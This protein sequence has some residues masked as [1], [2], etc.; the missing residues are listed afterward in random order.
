ML[1]ENENRTFTP[2]EILALKDQKSCINE[3]G[4]VKIIPAKISLKA[5]IQ[6]SIHAFAKAIEVDYEFNFGNEEGE[7]FLEA[8]RIRNRIAHPKSA[9]CWVISDTEERMVLSSWIWF[10]QHLSKVSSI[11]K[12]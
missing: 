10:S 6:L 5:N 1:C 7:T 8:V 9:K 4:K 3:N 11:I 2:E 12:D